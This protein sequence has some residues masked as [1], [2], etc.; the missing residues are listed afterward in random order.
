MISQVKSPIERAEQYAGTNRE[1]I[2]QKVVKTT[3]ESYAIS[4]FVLI[5]SIFLYTC[6]L[7]IG[8]SILI[9]YAQGNLGCGFFMMAALIPLFYIALQVFEESIRKNRL[10]VL[11]KSL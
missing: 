6:M 7:F 4:R 3:S 1:P 9:G 10:C 11:L 2:W 5:G 8:L